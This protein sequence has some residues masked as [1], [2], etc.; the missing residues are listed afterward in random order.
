MIGR[1]HSTS[2]CARRRRWSRESCARIDSPSI[3]SRRST[4]AA[5]DAGM[6]V[7]SAVCIEAFARSLARAVRSAVNGRKLPSGAEARGDRDG[8]S[9]EVRARPMTRHVQRDR[10]TDPEVGPQQRAREPRRGGAVDPHGQLHLVCHTREL[11]VKRG[12]VRRVERQQ[13]RRKP[14]RRR[15]RR[16]AEPFGDGCTP[17]RRSRSSAASGRRSQGP[18][19]SPGDHRARLTP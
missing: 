6:S 2:A 15:H 19:P 14:R 7:E 18:L 13:Q 9:L 3:A 10:S 4:A 5:T 16:V 8:L 17:R 11:G 12:G 1:G